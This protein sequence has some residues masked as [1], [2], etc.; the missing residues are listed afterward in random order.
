MHFHL[1]RCGERTRVNKRRG[2]HCSNTSAGNMK[3]VAGGCQADKCCHLSRQATDYFFF[4]YLCVVSGSPTPPPTITHALSPRQPT[5]HL[6]SME[7][8]RN[9]S[10]S[11]SIRTPRLNIRFS[12]FFLSLCIHTSVCEQSANSSGCHVCLQ[13]SYSA[14][15]ILKI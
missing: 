11:Q 5:A 7:Y 10:F 13:G 9:V 12:L 2:L 15:F 6:A 8:P 3:G 4:V 1:C 14:A